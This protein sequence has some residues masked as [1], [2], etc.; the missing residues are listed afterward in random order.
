MPPKGIWKKSHRRDA[1]APSAAIFA[2]AVEEDPAAEAEVEEEAWRQRTLL[3]IEDDKALARRLEE[4]GC[5]L[6]EAGRFH[7]ARVRLDEAVRRDPALASAHE[8]LAQ[9]LLE[10]GDAFA[11]VRAAEAACG[12]QPSWGVAYL[13][14]GRA[15]RN[16]GELRLSLGSLE[17]ALGRGLEA[18]DAAEAAEEAEEVEGLLVRHRV[19]AADSAADDAALVARD[20]RRTETLEPG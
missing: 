4:Q 12:C 13:T 19:I 2:A 5:V 6:A 16:L 17:A 14:L 8:S 7:E 9:V 18:D 1:L 10:L 15:Q 11:A 20:A 3:A